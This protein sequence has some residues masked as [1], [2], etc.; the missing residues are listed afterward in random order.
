[1]EEKKFGHLVDQDFLFIG[2]DGPVF[3]DEGGEQWI[4]NPSASSCIRGMAEQRSGR[5]ALWLTVTLPSKVRSPVDLRELRRLAS[6]W[7]WVAISGVLL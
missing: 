4:S 7:A 5:R 3:L 6:I 2:A 1:L